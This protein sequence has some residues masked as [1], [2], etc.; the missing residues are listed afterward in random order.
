MATA[1]IFEQFDPREGDIQSYLDRLEQYPEVFKQELGTVNQF[2]A[3][4]HMKE[5]VV[6][7]FHKARNVP[8]TLRPAVEKELDHMQQEGVIVPVEFSEWATT[9]VCIPKPD[10]RV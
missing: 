2:K 8:Y 7:V 6:P 3:T 10:G 5:N 1:R 9:L 4:L